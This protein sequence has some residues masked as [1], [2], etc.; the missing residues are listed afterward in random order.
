VIVLLVFVFGVFRVV[1]CGRSRIA[2][3]RWRRHRVSRVRVLHRRRRAVAGV[4]VR[5]RGIALPMGSVRIGR[6]MAV[7]TVIHFSGRRRQHGLDPDRRREV[8][9]R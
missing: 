5:R 6:L 3:G 8:G 2:L 9:A 1:R 7:M 4:R